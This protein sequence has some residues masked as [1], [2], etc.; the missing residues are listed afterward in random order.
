M[1]KTEIIQ[2]IYIKY[3]VVTKEDVKRILVRDYHMLNESQADLMAEGIASGLKSLGAKIAQVVSTI[4]KKLGGAVVQQVKKFGQFLLSF[5]NK[6]WQGYA[7]PK[8]GTLITGFYSP[9]GNFEFTEDLTENPILFI[10]NKLKGTTQPIP[11]AFLMKLSKELLNEVVGP[12]ETGEPSE[13]EIAAADAKLADYVRQADIEAGERD[14][15][16]GINSPEV[17]IEK[18]IAQIMPRFIKRIDARSDDSAPLP[19]FLLIGPPG[20]SKTFTI[21]A[22]KGLGFEVATWELAGEQDFTVKGLPKLEKDEKG[23]DVM[24]YVPPQKLPNR[25]DVNGKYIIFFDE[26]NRAPQEVYNVV[27]N[28]V[29]K[30]VLDGYI[31]PIKTGMIL[32]GNA[33]DGVIDSEDVKP[34]A[35]T[36]FQRIRSTYI[37]KYDPRSDIARTMADA[38]RKGYKTDKNDAWHL[39]SASEKLR[40]A[41]GVDDEIRKEAQEADWKKDLGGTLK[42]GNLTAKDNITGEMEELGK[43]TTFKNPIDDKVYG[44]KMGGQLAPIIENWKKYRALGNTGEFE[45]SKWYKEVVQGKQAETGAKTTGGSFQ[46]PVR[47]PITGAGGETGERSD[48]IVLGQSARELN[49][50]SNT[51]KEHALYDFMNAFLYGAPLSTKLQVNKP[52]DHFVKNWETKGYNSAP[53][54]YFLVNQ[55]YYLQIGAPAIAT[56]TKEDQDTFVNDMLGFYKREREKGRIL[57][58][59]VA[60]MAFSE[61]TPN[62]IKSI[63]DMK[64]TA[65]DEDESKANDANIAIKRILDVRS[66][67]QGRLAQL[68]NNYDTYRDFVSA[69]KKKLLELEKGKMDLD[70]YINVK[71]VKDKLNGD[72]ADIYLFVAENID[73]VIE[74]LDLRVNGIVDMLSKDKL[75][76][77]FA[78]EIGKVIINVSDKAAKATQ[79]AEETSTLKKAVS[80][81]DD[82]FADIDNHLSGAGKKSDSGEQPAPKKRGRPAGSKNKTEDLDDVSRGFMNLFEKLQ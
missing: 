3:G 80:S 53:E 51:M 79:S 76:T 31:V 48:F 72:E 33:G 40:S 39:K 61:F 30:G 28:F 57:D 29:H 65:Y 60:L 37:M 10:N 23:R 13:D 69:T 82:F 20:I 22:A 4:S 42:F 41:L 54:Y 45:N 2:E 55:E 35:E 19:S 11:E 36:I 62:Q 5:K 44:F 18:F 46:L 8:T 16:T 81:M 24:K 49:K 26:F 6:N 15:I 68:L 58:S 17:T 78:R 77:E 34:I 21:N 50:L 32:A 52:V 12:D 1:N 14:A 25:D 38:G 43:F 63:Q 64:E 27:M 75:K 47:K 9:S 67:F 66:D 71:A 70:Q 59:E 7:D 56:K 74:V 73:K